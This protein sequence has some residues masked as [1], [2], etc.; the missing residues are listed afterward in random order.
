MNDEKTPEQKIKISL[1]AGKMLN[2]GQRLQT[3][4][5]VAFGDCSYDSIKKT[6]KILYKM[7]RD[8]KVQYFRETKVWYLLDD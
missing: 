7:R 5:K 1:V 2:A 4:A 3:L 6:Q 8:Y